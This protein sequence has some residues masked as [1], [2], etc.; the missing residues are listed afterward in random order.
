MNKMWFFLFFILVVVFATGSQK[1]QN[2]DPEFK[3]MCIERTPNN[4]MHMREMRNG[5]FTSDKSCWGCM[6]DDGLSHYC[7]KDDYVKYKQEMEEMNM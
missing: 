3:K 1:N 6:S 7:S 5:E 4:W 2:Y